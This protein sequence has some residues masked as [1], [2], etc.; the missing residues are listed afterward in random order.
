MTRYF[1]LLESQIPLPKRDSKTEMEQTIK[2]DQCQL[3]N[4]VTVKL[5]SGSVVRGTQ[6]GY[7]SKHRRTGNFLPGGAVNHLPKNF[8]QV[9]RIFP[10]RTVEKKRGPYDATTEASGSIL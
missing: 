1:Y 6:R 8:S 10:K 2:P 7:S 4:N 3:I 5:N 9:A